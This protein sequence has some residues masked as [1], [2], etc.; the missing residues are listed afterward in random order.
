MAD[1]VD[2]LMERLRDT[3]TL[4][5]K[6][7]ENGWADWLQRDHDW[8]AQRDFRGVQHLF[9]AFGGVG[10]FSDLLIHPANGHE[11]PEDEVVPVNQRLNALCGELYAL[12]A[13]IR[14]EV[15]HES[16]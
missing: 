8:I 9:N 7:K 1:E 4:L 15:E 16:T 13:K 10:S 2:K 14:R 3:I 12:A 11:L 5:R 6:Y